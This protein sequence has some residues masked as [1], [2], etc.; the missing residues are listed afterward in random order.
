M[1][2]SATG[3]F[4]GFGNNF[5]GIFDLGGHQ[6][7]VTGAFT[8]GFK[9]FNVSSA[10]ITYNGLDDFNGPYNV[11]I[12]TPPSFIGLDTIDIKF[13][14]ADGKELHVTGN[15]TPALAQRQNAVGLGRWTML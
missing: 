4:K 8:Q 10:T 7:A 12:S 14:S 11:E 3:S 13:E 6:V 5:S 2:K 15:L 9:E 1:S